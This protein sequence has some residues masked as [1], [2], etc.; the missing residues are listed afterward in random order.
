MLKTDFGGSR[1]IFLAGDK[2]AR[3]RRLSLFLRACLIGRITSQT[4]GDCDMGEQGCHMG[5]NHLTY[6]ASFF[7]LK[8]GEN[9]VKMHYN[10]TLFFVKSTLLDVQQ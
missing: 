2:E 8:T 7:T 4:P 10:Q 6:G 1:W 9:S 3:Q 5:D